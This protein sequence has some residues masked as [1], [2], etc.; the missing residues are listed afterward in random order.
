MGLVGDPCRYRDLAGRAYRPGMES[1]A[2]G[3]QAGTSWVGRRGCAWAS[4]HG[5]VNNTRGSR[6]A[7]GR[8]PVAQ[9]RDIW[10]LGPADLTDVLR[11]H[12]GP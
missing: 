9:R 6:D 2:A 5:T 1:R 10:S 7:S 11:M 8:N 3:P 4:A 12:A